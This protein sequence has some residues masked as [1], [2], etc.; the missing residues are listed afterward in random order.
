MGEILTELQKLNSDVDHQKTSVTSTFRLQELTSSLSAKLFHNPDILGHLYD[1]S[2]L[3]SEFSQDHISSQRSCQRPESHES[4]MPWCRPQSSNNDPL[5]RIN[6]GKCRIENQKLLEKSREDVL[7]I[8]DGGQPHPHLKKD[9]EP[10][11]D[12]TEEYI[13]AS[14]H[15]P[16]TKAK[17]LKQEDHRRHGQP[18]PGNG[19]LENDGE[20]KEE[21][22]L[23][24]ACVI[25]EISIYR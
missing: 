5:K 23:E 10:L 1:I 16:K 20:K 24:C 4:P 13:Q 15:Q 2:D 9:A 6:E 17:E 22:Q 25:H 18:G 11:T 12:I 3:C 21:E 14:Q 8:D 19:C 7:H